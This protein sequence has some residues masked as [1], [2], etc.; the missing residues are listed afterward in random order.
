MHVICTPLTE[1]QCSVGPWRLLEL[2][3]GIWLG[4]SNYRRFL[5][6]IL[7]I[8]THSGSCIGHMYCVV[9]ALSK[10]I[11]VVLRCMLISNV[12]H[13]IV[14]VYIVGHLQLLELDLPLAEWH[15]LIYRVLTCCKTLI[16]QSCQLFNALHY[17]KTFIY[18]D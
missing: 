7:H 15:K 12:C 14:Y 17:L 18:R 10:Y 6:A 16:H 5:H 3:Y 4:C 8:L 2:G 13:V 11:P 1:L 9:Q